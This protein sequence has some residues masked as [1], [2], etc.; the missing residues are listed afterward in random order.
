MKTGKSPFTLSM[1]IDYDVHILRMPPIPVNRFDLPNT[2]LTSESE[3][4]SF[5]LNEWYKKYTHI[6]TELP[7][8]V[9]YGNFLM[10][11]TTFID[12]NMVAFEQQRD[13]HVAMAAKDAVQGDAISVQSTTEFTS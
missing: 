5:H 6:S 8:W 4:C 1:K 10:L 3:A 9:V 13:G 7:A 12:K 2:G 11:N